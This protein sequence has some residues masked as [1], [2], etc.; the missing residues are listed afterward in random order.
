MLKDYQIDLKTGFL[1]PAPA[2]VGPGLNADQ[3]TMFI[4]EYTK[5]FNFTKAAKAVLTT[6]PVIV[7]HLK[8]DKAFKE[9]FQNVVDEVLDDVEESLYKQS[10]KSPIAAMQFLKAKRSSE[11]GP[12]RKQEPEDKTSDKLKDLLK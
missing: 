9:A 12:P 4:A 6:R 2:H 5:S 7:H 3:K 8:E 1:T 11:W 10:K